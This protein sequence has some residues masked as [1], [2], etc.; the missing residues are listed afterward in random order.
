M[1]S[2]AVLRSEVMKSLIKNFGLVDAER[3]IDIIKRDEFD[4]TEWQ[5][6]LWK[7]KTTAEIHNEAK[8]YYLEKK[9]KNL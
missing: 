9:E 4:Y 7:D 5:R 8:Q 6:D 2:E 1:K 3:F